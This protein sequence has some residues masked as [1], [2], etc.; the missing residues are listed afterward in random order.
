MILE[1]AVAWRYAIVSKEWGSATAGVAGGISGAV[2]SGR[3]GHVK[4]RA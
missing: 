3:W 2:L 4:G 1:G